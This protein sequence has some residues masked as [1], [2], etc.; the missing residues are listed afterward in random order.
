M[1]RGD[2]KHFSPYY[3][4]YIIYVFLSRQLHTN[5]EENPTQLFPYDRPEF[6]TGYWNTSLFI[7]DYASWQSVH[8]HSAWQCLKR[9]R[10]E[11]KREEKERL[12]LQ[13]PWGN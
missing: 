8:M 2:I 7:L 9:V 1:I 11:R 4:I 3:I 6:P 5:P 12:S 13:Y 10:E